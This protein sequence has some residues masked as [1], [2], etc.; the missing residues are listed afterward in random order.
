MTPDRVRGGLCTP[1]KWR[2]FHLDE[3]RRRHLQTIKEPGRVTRPSF[4]YPA[5]RQLV[6]RRL[7]NFHFVVHPRWQA[8]SASLIHYNI[9]FFHPRG[10]LWKSIRMNS[11]SAPP[12]TV[13]AHNACPSSSWNWRI[14]L[15]HGSQGTHMGGLT[16]YEANTFW[17]WTINTYRHR[18]RFFCLAE[19]C[20]DHVLTKNKNCNGQLLL[21]QFYSQLFNFY[22]SL[23]ANSPVSTTSFR[24]LHHT[25]D[26]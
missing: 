4:L 15:L 5:H 14:Y 22:F 1:R 23:I 26:N 21:E 11:N 18:V 9:V 12:K 3:P 7:H 25:C 13:F 19:N 8:A 10:A 6:R 2:H 20:F 16:F 24:S 17:L